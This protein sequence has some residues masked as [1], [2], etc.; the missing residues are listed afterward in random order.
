MKAQSSYA[1]GA[2]RFGAVSLCCAAALYLAFDKTRSYGIIP[3][4]PSYGGS[5]SAR[6]PIERGL[7][8]S[9]PED[10]EA[11][12]LGGMLWITHRNPDGTVADRLSFSGVKD[13]HAWVET[14]PDFCDVNVE[15]LALRMP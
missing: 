12:W 15:K 13:Y 6:I 1:I 8:F 14:H 4:G 10:W 11:E 5:Q 7:L 2:V 9:L 3:S